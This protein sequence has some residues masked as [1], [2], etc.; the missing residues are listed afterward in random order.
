MA[1]EQEDTWSM[2]PSDELLDLAASKVESFESMTD[3]S[4]SLLQRSY[5][6]TLQSKNFHLQLLNNIECE[7]KSKLISELESSIQHA[8][9]DLRCVTNEIRLQRTVK[10]ERI[11]EFSYP[12]IIED[13]GGE[14]D[15]TIF[16][17]LIGDC[18]D[19]TDPI[20]FN[21]QYQSLVQYSRCNP[22]DERKLLQLFSLKLKGDA[23][24]YFTSF[25][26]SLPLKEKIKCLLVVFSFRR[27]I[28]DKLL[29]LEQFKR[30]EYE[31]L[32]SC[33]LRL[34]SIL[35]ASSS[36]IH[37][38]MRATRREHILTQAI[39][40][41][42]LP[43]VQHRLTK[44]RADKLA[45]G[46]FL[47]SNDLLKTAMSFEESVSQ[48]RQHS[49]PFTFKDPFVDLEKPS[50]S[51]HHHL[52]HQD[53][54]STNKES[55]LSNDYLVTQP[56]PSPWKTPSNVKKQN[57]KR[58]DDGIEALNKKI[59]QLA[60][61]YQKGLQTGNKED[62]VIES[63]GVFDSPKTDQ[64]GIG[65]E[66]QNMREDMVDTFLRAM[67][68]FYKNYDYEKGRNRPTYTAFEKWGSKFK[69]SFSP[70]YYDGNYNQRPQNPS[71]SYNGQNRQNYFS[72]RTDERRPQFNGNVQEKYAFYPRRTDNGRI[73]G[74]RRP[75]P[76]KR[77]RFSEFVANDSN[78]QYEQRRKNI[79]QHPNHN[80]EHL[81]HADDYKENIPSVKRTLDGQPKASL[82][83]NRSNQSTPEPEPSSSTMNN[84]PPPTAFQNMPDLSPRN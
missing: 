75:S 44:F 63:H 52:D 21:S 31:K 15:L 17:S 38:S 23:L 36:M 49:I 9:H 84:V 69:K 11:D 39:F 4:L 60:E 6:E 65:K 30:K 50:T 22:L 14:L 27:S 10:D 81:G 20:R 29:E 80:P 56:M 55:D 3:D 64:H 40:S 58:V 82:Y 25:Y 51:R 79:D 8:E 67:F 47:S 45:H 73:F 19:S 42:S 18:F 2:S 28:G 24:L 35:D 32:D 72:R 46:Q 12:T 37:P 34:A 71:A 61:L 59:D 1:F 68:D 57:P 41:L 26:S 70:V 5:G 16:N 53:R 83:R 76:Q 43:P 54:H 7:N 78:R 33:Y 77:I 13:S 74:D 62:Y 66:A 48:G